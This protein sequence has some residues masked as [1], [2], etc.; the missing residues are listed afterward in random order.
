MEGL[1]RKSTTMVGGGGGECRSARKERG[2]VGRRTGLG[3]TAS[4][5]PVWPIGPAPQCL[6]MTFL[7][8]Q[9]SVIAARK[10]PRA[11]TPPGSSRP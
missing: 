5:G 2:W 7:H 6:L 4:Q 10:D 3:W 11:R 8:G 9:Q 1:G